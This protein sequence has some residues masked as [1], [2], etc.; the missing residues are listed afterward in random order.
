MKGVGAE[1]IENPVLLP[2][3]G[4]IDKPFHVLKADVIY[5][6]IFNEPF[7]DNNHMDVGFGG[8]GKFLWGAINSIRLVYKDNRFSNR[9]NAVV[10]TSQH[11]ATPN[12]AGFPNMLH[13]SSGDLMVNANMR[14][15]TLRGVGEAVYETY[16]CGFYNSAANFAYAIVRWGTA[17]SGFGG[18][19]VTTQLN[20]PAGAVASFAWSFILPASHPVYS[21]FTLGRRDFNI[22]LIWSKRLFDAGVPSL[23]VF[24]NGYWIASAPVVN[25]RDLSTIVGSSGGYVN[26]QVTRVGG[27]AATSQSIIDNLRIRPVFLYGDGSVSFPYSP[28]WELTSDNGPAF[29]YDSIPYSDNRNFDAAGVSATY[30]KDSMDLRIAN[31]GRT[32]FYP[33]NCQMPISRN[34]IPVTFEHTLWNRAQNNPFNKKPPIL[35]ADTSLD[36]GDNYIASGSVYEATGRESF[37]RPVQT[38]ALNFSAP[39]SQMPAMIGFD[40]ESIWPGMM[41]GQGDSGKADHNDKWTAIGTNNSKDNVSDMRNE[42]SY[43]GAVCEFT[44]LGSPASNSGNGGWPIQCNRS[45]SDPLALYLDSAAIGA[46]VFD[47]ALRNIRFVGLNPNNTDRY[48][49]LMVAMKETGPYAPALPSVYYQGDLVV[50]RLLNNDM[51]DTSGSFAAGLKTIWANTFDGIALVDLPQRLGI[52]APVFFQYSDLAIVPLGDPKTTKKHRIYWIGNRAGTAVGSYGFDIYYTDLDN[53]GETIV[54][55]S[56]Q[57]VNLDYNI[58]YGSAYYT[59]PLHFDVIQP[60]AGKFVM[61]ATLGYTAIPGMGAPQLE[62]RVVTVTYISADGIN[63]TSP[64]II[65]S[66]ALDPGNTVAGSQSSQFAFPKLSYTAYGKNAGEVLL[67]L[68]HVDCITRIVSFNILETYI[69]KGLLDNIYQQGSNTQTTKQWQ[70]IINCNRLVYESTQVIPP[71]T[72]SLSHVLNAAAFRDRQGKIH[73]AINKKPQGIV[74]PGS[75]FYGGLYYIVVDDSNYPN[76]YIKTTKYADSSSPQDVIGNNYDIVSMSRFTHDNKAIHANVAG[77]NGY[78]CVN[79]PSFSPTYNDCYFTY[80]V[81]NNL[82]SPPILQIDKGRDP[83]YRLFQ[84]TDLGEIYPPGAAWNHSMGYPSQLIAITNIQT[85]YMFPAPVANIPV[86]TASG[87]TFNNAVSRNKRFSYAVPVNGFPYTLRIPKDAVAIKCRFR[88]TGA[89]AGALALGTGIFTLKFED[90][91]F[92][93]YPGVFAQ[94]AGIAAMYISFNTDTVAMGTNI[95]APLWSQSGNDFTVFRDIYIVGTNNSTENRSYWN[96]Y[97]ERVPNAV[98][99]NKKS[100]WMPKTWVLLNDTPIQGPLNTNYVALPTSER[101]TFGGHD[102]DGAGLWVAPNAAS[103]K[104]FQAYF[105]LF[106]GSPNRI[107]WSSDGSGLSGSPGVGV[108][109]YT[110]AG[111]CLVS[112]VTPGLQSRTKR[113]DYSKS[114]NCKAVFQIGERYAPDRTGNRAGLSSEVNGGYYGDDADARAFSPVGWS[115]GN[116]TVFVVPTPEN[117]ELSPDRFQFNYKFIYG[118]ESAFDKQPFTSWMCCDDTPPVRICFDSTKFRIPLQRLRANCLWMLNTNLINLRVKA[119]SVPS[120][121]GVAPFEQAFSFAIDTGLVTQRYGVTATE[122]ILAVTDSTKNWIANQFVDIDSPFYIIHNTL[123]WYGGK[124][125]KNNKNTIWFKLSTRRSGANYTQFAVGNLFKIIAPSKIVKFTSTQEY[126]YWAIEIMPNAVG[127]IQ[128][129]SDG[130][131]RVNEIG[132]GECITLSEHP[133]V[134]FIETFKNVTKI[135]SQ[136]DGSDRMEL[137]AGRGLREF[138]LKYTNINKIDAYKIIDNFKVCKQNNIPVWFALTEYNSK[139]IMLCDYIDSELGVEH[140][141]DYPPD[142]PFVTEWTRDLIHTLTLRLRQRI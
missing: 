20:C 31:I 32:G 138:E 9:H 1:V 27:F 65:T 74:T 50:G 117:I 66:G 112:G 91:I 119:N 137:S 48:K 37:P 25:T 2:P 4:S 105:P 124:I 86:P 55:G 127:D 93:H 139:D 142:D 113:F 132:L 49:A 23:H 51:L 40:H 83:I 13:Q 78:S 29:A 46:E 47:N 98:A 94:Y 100:R 42:E 24:I 71:L 82:G 141:G 125:I 79:R 44:G 120:A 95:A 11:F 7:N 12:V 21:S 136:N 134:G 16:L 85:W 60:E 5:N 81:M 96:I 61:V 76:K 6:A 33:I 45:P 88:Y 126:R 87:M 70:A 128:G 69:F 14:N 22:G 41:N 118:V 18:V 103:C 57:L 101:Y 115:V 77:Y 102:G 135:A 89:Y 80:N 68:T 133:D 129:Y 84:P 56:R 92:G 35:M 8:N 64:T 109:G 99:I 43:A 114:S 39:N 19:R 131:A 17:G 53:N 10:A 116:N 106:K 110:A 121:W 36:I 63:F 34:I 52:T 90:I 28:T 67:S 26:A 59:M 107:L 30:L 72:L 3:Y 123:P 75:E 15:I 97:I 130:A 54:N 140:V 73:V 122:N 111:D 62:T 38:T 108:D 104:Y 58:Y